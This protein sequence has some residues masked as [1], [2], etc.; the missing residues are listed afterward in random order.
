MGGFDD[1]GPSWRPQDQD[2]D[3]RMHGRDDEFGQGQSGYGSGRLGD[4]RSMEQF[5]N[6]NQGQRPGSHE[7]HE[8]GYGID[9]RFAGGR[10][11][12]E[13]WTDRGDRPYPQWDQRDRDHDANTTS[14]RTV[15]G[16]GYGQQQ[17]GLHRGK[18]P[19]NFTRSDE[20]IREQICEL[21]SDDEHVDATHVEVTVKG[22]EVTLTG[23]VE[24]RQ[25]K[26]MAEDLAERASGVKDIHN[27]LKCGPAPSTATK[28]RS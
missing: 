13:Y 2:R 10:G 6:R 27:Q 23:T 26:R 15:G 1:R 14:R 24:D 28:S 25:M 12:E 21:L 19:M 3:D 17:R 8:R 4:D 16:P 5:R 20:R 7:Q 9:D 11:G 18:G 22:G